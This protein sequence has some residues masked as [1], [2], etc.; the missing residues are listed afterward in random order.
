MKN[1]NGFTLTEIL[2]A[3]MIVGLIGVALASLTTAASRESGVGSSRVMLRNNLSIALRQLRQDVHHASRVL[4]VKGPLTTAPNTASGSTPAEIP[5][6]VLANNVNVQGKRID[7]DKAKEF[8]AYCFLRGNQFTLSS[9]DAVQPTT[10]STSPAADGGVIKRVVWQGSSDAD[11]TV[12][13]ETAADFCPADKSSRSVSVWL[14]HVKFISNSYTISDEKHYP[15]PLFTLLDYNGTT[16]YNN[17]ASAVSKGA[18]LGVNI[19]LELPSYPVVN[20][21][22][23]ERILLSNGGALTTTP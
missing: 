2:L 13:P 1:K 10:P 20:E 22:I 9:G 18:L 6:L 5:L 3:A 15:V 14:N 7:S 4:F 17:N 12:L 11:D 8:I 16:S 19:I 21:V 23:E